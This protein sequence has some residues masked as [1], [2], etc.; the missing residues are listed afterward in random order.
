MAKRKVSTA[1]AKVKKEIVRPTN[2][3][4]DVNVITKWRNAAQAHTRRLFGL[5]E[6]PTQY[7]VM[8][9]PLPAADATVDDIV[10]RGL[11]PL[12]EGIPFTYSIHF[13][14]TVWKPHEVWNRRLGTRLDTEIGEM[15]SH[16]F[17]EVDGK[18]I[19]VAYAKYRNPN[20]LWDFGFY[21]YYEDT[22][23]QL[24]HKMWYG[25]H[26]PMRAAIKAKS[27]LMTTLARDE[28]LHGI[29]WLNPDEN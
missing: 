6:Y 4:M 21:T 10:L 11:C 26:E 25:I 19:C 27:D 22:D 2:N 28:S 24:F 7:A 14:S 5:G 15:E 29:V 3:Y 17:I 23:M 20:D 1:P 18:V 12:E 16:I 8:I 9:P 13:E